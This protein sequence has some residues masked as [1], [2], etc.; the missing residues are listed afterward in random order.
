LQRWLAL[1]TGFEPPAKDDVG[2]SKNGVAAIMFE[3][4]DKPVIDSLTLD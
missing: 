3:F 1:C 4:S 2:Y